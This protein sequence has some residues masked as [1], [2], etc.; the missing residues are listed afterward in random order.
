MVQPISS[1]FLHPGLSPNF[2]SLTPVPVSTILFSESRY[3]SFMLVIC[4]LLL[5]SLFFDLCQT[6]SLPVSVANLELIWQGLLGPEIR[7]SSVHN[8]AL[9]KFRSGKPNTCPTNRGF[10]ARNSS[11]YPRVRNSSPVPTILAEKLRISKSTPRTISVRENSFKSLAR[12]LICQTCSKLILF[13][14]LFLPH[15]F[16]RARYL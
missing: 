14:P 7:H 6:P 3:H 16:V 11:I 2:L 5:P 8:I 1:A 4:C 15:L 9:T 13:S 12:T 10:L